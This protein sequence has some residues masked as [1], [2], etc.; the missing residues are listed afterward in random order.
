M[1]HRSDQC[2]GT[3]L[4]LAVV[5]GSQAAAGASAL[6]LEADAPV[7][8]NDTTSI[9]FDARGSEQVEPL[10]PGDRFA[11]VYTILYVHSVPSC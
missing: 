2:L 9:G 4:G 3:L 5:R 10:L 8:A 7:R 11:I 6:M 1:A